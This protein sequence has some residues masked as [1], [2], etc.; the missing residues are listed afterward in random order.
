MHVLADSG[1][2]VVGTAGDFPVSASAHGARV[3]VLNARSDHTLEQAL[4][5]RLPARVVFSS[6]QVVVLR[7]RG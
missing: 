2:E 1:F 7:R 5:Q 3:F 4:I 6:P